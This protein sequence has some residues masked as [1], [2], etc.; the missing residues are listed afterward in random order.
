[1]RP[2]FAVP[3]AGKR[4]G[5]R[6]RK[7]SPKVQKKLSSKQKNSICKCVALVLTKCTGIIMTNRYVFGHKPLYI[8]EINLICILY[9]LIYHLYGGV[10]NV[11]YNLLA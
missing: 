1:L 4:M 10:V 2:G 11:C 7:L 8:L 6:D 9:K 3:E 5:N